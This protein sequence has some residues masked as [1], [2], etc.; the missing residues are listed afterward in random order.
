MLPR[1][2]PRRGNRQSTGGHMPKRTLND[3]IIKAYIK[4][5]RPG[6]RPD[7]LMD[8]VVPKFGIRGETWILRDRFPR[9]P[10]P[11]RRELGKYGELTLEQARTKARHWLELLRRGIDPAEEEEQQRLAAQRKRKNTFLPIAE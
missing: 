9:S 10:N 8:T 2:C 6:L 3:R 5:L 1:C 11:T 7:D 4:A